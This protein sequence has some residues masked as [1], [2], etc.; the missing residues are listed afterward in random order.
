MRV[1]DFECRLTENKCQQIDFDIRFG[2]RIEITA[3]Q[4][5]QLKKIDAIK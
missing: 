3:I 1:T 2:R 4:E 5:K